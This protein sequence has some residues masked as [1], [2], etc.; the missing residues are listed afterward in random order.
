MAAN[1]KVYPFNP[2]DYPDDAMIRIEAGSPVVDVD[3][4]EQLNRAVH[5]GYTAHCQGDRGHAFIWQER[6][7][8]KVFNWQHAEEGP[9]RLIVFLDLE[10]AAAYTLTCVK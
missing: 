3:A 8:F 1:F 7:K 2:D 5:S 10:D 4:E 9:A 6:G